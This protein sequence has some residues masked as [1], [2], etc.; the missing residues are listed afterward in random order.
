MS[1]TSLTPVEPTEVSPD[2]AANSVGGKRL[3]VLIFGVAGL[4]V[5]FQ[6]SF[7]VLASSI[8]ADAPAPATEF[9]IEKKPIP[10]TTNG[11]EGVES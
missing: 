1:T 2:K 10:S 9:S 3:A 7:V 4:M 5:V 8:D 11:G 6:L